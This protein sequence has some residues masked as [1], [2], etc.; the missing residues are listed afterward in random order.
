MSGLINNSDMNFV[1]KSWGW[2]QWICNNEKY[3]GKILFIKQGQ[4]CSLH[5]H[6]L[7][8][9]VLF[10]Q[11]GSMQLITRDIEVGAVRWFDLNEGDAFHVESWY[12][13]QMVA[14]KDTTILE[15][16]TQHFDSDSYRILNEE[17]WKV[18]RY[19]KIL[20]SGEF[21]TSGMMIDLYTTDNFTL[22]MPYPSDFVLT[23]ITHPTDSSARVTHYAVRKGDSVLFKDK[24]PSEFYITPRD[25]LKISPPMSFVVT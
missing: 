10:V 22:T 7:K 9:E 3:C 12:V 14:L 4:R 20:A 11:S 24:L 19:E 13:H 25:S 15:F 2:E 1:P 18:Y 16:S 5:F 17:D 8:D 6:K 21:D 23:N